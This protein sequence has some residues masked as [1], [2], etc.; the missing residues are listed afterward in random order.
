MTQPTPPLLEPNDSKVLVIGWDAADWR[1]IRPLLEQGKMPN[2][3]RMMEQGTHGN[4]TTLNPVLSPM[5]WT[6]ISTGKRP[7][8]HG[9]WG[10][11]EPMPN[12]KGIRPI[13]NMNRRCKAIWNMLSQVDK[14]CNVVGFWP[15]HPAE[16][17]NGVM[18]S[19][20]YHK[21]LPIKDWK[22]KSEDDRPMPGLQGWSDEQWPMP[23]GS[24]EPV[25]M[26]TKLSEFRLHPSELESEHIAPF[27][28]NFLELQEK[29]DPRLHSCSK[30]LADASTVHAA[31][32]ALMNLEPWDF[33]AVYYDAIDHFGHGFMKYH[34]PRNPWI[35]EEDFEHFKDVVVSGYLMHDMMLGT[36]LTLAGD[37]ATVILLSDHGF[38]PDH[39][40]PAEIPAE[41]AGPA[42]EH[43]PYG[44]FV[45]KGPGIRKGSQLTGASLLDITPTVLQIFGLPVGSD[46][47]GKVL[48]NLFD[49]A[50]GTKTVP[51]W[52]AIDGPCSAGMHAGNETLDNS[53]SAEMMKQLVELGY[54]DEPD[55]DASESIRQCERELNYNLAQSHMDAGEFSEAWQLLIQLWADWPR[56]HRF[57]LKLIACLAMLGRWD[58]RSEA[59][60]L[61]E[62][63]V[64]EAAQWARSEL[65]RMEPDLKK[66][67]LLSNP[68]VSGDEAA[69]ESPA[70]EDPGIQE[71]A[72]DKNTPEATLRKIRAD[73]RRLTALL[74]PMELTIA[75]LK[76]DQK[77]VN[78][79]LQNDPPDLEPFIQLAAQQPTP[80]LLATLG[81]AYVRLGQPPKAQ[82]FFE[83]ALQ[84]DSEY[85]LAHRGLAEVALEQDQWEEAVSRSLS[86]IDLQYRDPRSHFILAQA[87]GQCQE[88]ELSRSAFQS[89]IRLM[90]GNSAV[91]EAYR[92][93][94]NRLNLTEEAAA[95]LERIDH[96][97][98]RTRRANDIDQMADDDLA[99]RAA[100][101]DELGLVLSQAD[102]GDTTE[103]TI[104]VVSGL[105]RSGTSMMM[106]MLAAGGL[107]AF[108][109]NLRQPDAD[110]PRGYYEE[111]RVKGLVRDNTWVASAEGHALKVVAPLLPYLPKGPQYRVLFMDRDLRC[112]VKSQ[113]VM[114][115][116]GGYRGARLP[117]T[118]LM[119][120]YI[121]QLQQVEQ[122][123]A[124]RD[125]MT[126]LFLDY[127]ATVA[128][129]LGA[130]RQVGQWLSPSLDVANMASAVDSELQRQKPQESAAVH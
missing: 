21:A 15:S 57:G 45:A 47:D 22:P 46:M 89:A 123:I 44:I 4:I 88:L 80:E 53:Q 10:F 7:S 120:E 30:I 122:L 112:V 23:P 3:K 51:S 38:H 19:N 49:K 9:I 125:D 58:E 106:Q 61:F 75:W 126:A 94:L 50:T 12:G 66:A 119:Q 13:T 27:I 41:P 43:R 5:L 87:L 76:L 25:R 102:A 32:T 64:A 118:R 105:P 2:L 104:T 34:P 56:E 62:T 33:M 28:P 84:Q 14:K 71:P 95:E 52:D 83:Q 79:D 114:L 110:N 98:E 6:S 55:D 65:E 74:R 130:A 68:K 35:G 82:Q 16:P 40:R 78:E 18:V 26:A 29:K 90:P 116:R 73:F 81:N 77:L 101:R 1:V 85:A 109:D 124:S 91:S 11:S 113:R 59:I 97:R 8:K 39:L 60:A 31:A 48:A 37:D 67:G 127:D 121:K 93:L 100:R 107:P 17:I 129:P 128:D 69:A 20:W 86:A 111:E 70:G 42:V 99:T 96:I 63:N 117:N 24:V 108:T 115:D 36:L 72:P 54:I 103:K 92:N